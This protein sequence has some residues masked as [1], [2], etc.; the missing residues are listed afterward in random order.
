VTTCRLSPFRALSLLVFVA[1]ASFLGAGTLAAPGAVAAAPPSTTTTLE[2]SLTCGDGTVDALE[3]CDEGMANTDDGGAWCATDCS[4]TPC[5]AP[6]SRSGGNP[7]ASDALFALRASISAATC[8]LRVC[9]VNNSGT[10]TATDALLI[11]QAAVALPVTLECFAPPEPITCVGR[12]FATITE[13]FEALAGDYTMTLDGG[14]GGFYDQYAAGTNLAMRVL[15]N[16]LGNKFVSTSID[17]NTSNGAAYYDDMRMGESWEDLAHE[18]NVYF[19]AELGSTKI[20]QC[21]KTTGQLTFVI[22][23][24][25]GGPNFA[26]LVTQ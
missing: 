19:A 18:V 3:D 15:P 13:V 16:F 25:V 4:M 6:L 22:Q 24:A 14:T 11:L 5:G 8:D 17:G 12:S 9:D 10:I 2:V 1:A 21:D 26:R 7:V 20:L 23:V